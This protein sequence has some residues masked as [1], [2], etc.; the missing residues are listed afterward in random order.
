MTPLRSSTR[1]LS[2]ASVLLL[3]SCSGGGEKQEEYSGIMDA[4]TVRV[5]A[6]SSG[7]IRAVHAEEGGAVAAGS[8]L[9]VI[10]TD[11]LAAQLEQNAAVAEEIGHQR[12]AAA[13]AIAAAE[14][15]RDNLR[16]RLVRYKA[17]LASNAVT[18]QA[19]DDLQAQL[20]AAEKQ[21]GG[22]RRSLEA[23]DSKRAQTGAARTV[24]ERQVTDA[25]V[26]APIAGTVLVRYAEA[27]E[28]AAPGSAICELA[29]LTRMWTKIYVDEKRLPAVRVGQRAEIRIDGSDTTLP[30]S[31]VWISDKAEFTPKS[32]LT[33]ET[34]TALVY[35]VKIAVENGARL[36]KIG[37]PVTVVLTR[38]S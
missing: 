11:K 14:I 15:T 7:V 37:M 29:D 4:T 1:A 38:G 5:S 26:T 18:Q 21:I 27:G 13:S 34:R 22:N 33:Q 9:A 25:T 32:I 30:G 3:A 10:E 20:D 28:V 24:L 8:V 23:L 12:D 35:P 2:L 31:V 6:M 19:V 36:L 17:L 16:A